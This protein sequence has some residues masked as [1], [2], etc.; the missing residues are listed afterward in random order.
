MNVRSGAQIQQLFFA[1][2][3]NKEQAKGNLPLER[4]FKMP[5][6]EGAIEEGKKASKK[7]LDDALWKA[8]NVKYG[9][10]AE[11]VTT[12][13]DEDQLEHPLELLQHGNIAIR[14]QAT[15]ELGRVHCSLRFIRCAR[16]SLQT[17]GGD[18]H[19]RTALGMYDHIQQPVRDGN[20]L[21]EWDGG[22]NGDQP[23]PKPLVKDMWY[24]SQAEVRDWQKRQQRQAQE[25][26][27]VS[28]ILGRRRQLPDPTVKKGG[29]AKGHA[30]R[31]AINTP[32]QGSAADMATA[33]MLTIAANARPMELDRKLLLQVH[34]EVILQGPKESVE[35][36]ERVVRK[37]M[38]KPFNGQG[39]TEVDL[40]VE[41]KHADVV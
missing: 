3:P 13:A 40:I 15:E 1:G 28:T 32:I 21:E 7:D 5:S 19:S 33:A 41:S 38:M 10:A 22:P 29:K 18:F 16:P 9:D 11:E 36:A 30:M 27:Y 20:C 26:S 25:K 31:A 12:L 39:L 17:L 35:E 14:D 2:T 8:Y 37:C 6:V 24:A 23:P 4:T 34:D